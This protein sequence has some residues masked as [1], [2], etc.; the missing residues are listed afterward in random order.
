MRPID[1]MDRE[2]CGN[3]AGIAFDIDDTVTRH[4]QLELPAFRAMHE[5]RAGGLRLIAVTG[6]PLGW[7]DVLA[8]HW[9][10]DAAVGE[11]GAGWVWRD[12][13]I[14]REGYFED[15]EGRGR[16]PVTFERVRRR[17]AD[18]LPHVKPAIDQRARRCDLAFDVGETVQLPQPDIDHLVALIEETGAR[19]AVSSVHAHAIP[20]DW[21]KARGV[22]RAARDALGVEI[23]DELPRWLFIG[24]SEN[25]SAAFA[26]FPVS[27]GV[28]NVERYVPRMRQPPRFVTRLDR[29]RGFAE[30]ASHVL[31]ARRPKRGK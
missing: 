22:V 13:E 28:A 16:Y 10:V 31:A 20:G 24:D 23:V 11:N 26:Y 30:L 27:V 12:G 15:L 8:L 2:T 1:E 3:L 9:P 4:G 17:V 18:A 6:R 14:P 25:D 29:G 19:S 7:V 5:L 21:D